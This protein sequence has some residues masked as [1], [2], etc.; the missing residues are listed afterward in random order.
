MALEDTA[1]ALIQKFG[2]GRTVSL[3]VPAAAAADPAKPWEVDPTSTESSISSLPAVVTP[4][5]QNV[6][7]GNSVRQGDETV[8]IA[9]KS[10]GTT[11]PSTADKI[12]DD[13]VEKNV[14]AVQRIRP[15]TVDYLYKLQ[16]RR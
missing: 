13:G 8:L 14:V 2:Q 3:L 16:V 10:L 12:L 11:I 6:I 15:G 1:L 5:A 9:G 7:D 4:V